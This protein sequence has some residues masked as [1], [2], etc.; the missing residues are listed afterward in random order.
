MYK[1]HFGGGDVPCRDYRQGGKYVD[2]PMVQE[3]ID[4]GCHEGIGNQQRK[5]G[6]GSYFTA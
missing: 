5:V 3:L 2:E 1:R 4:F 6:D